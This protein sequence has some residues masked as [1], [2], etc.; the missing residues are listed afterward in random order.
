FYPYSEEQHLQEL[1][2]YKQELIAKYTKHGFDPNRSD[3]DWQKVHSDLERAKGYRGKSQALRQDFYQASNYLKESVEQVFENQFPLFLKKAFG[4]GG[5]D[6]YKI[7][8]L[9]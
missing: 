3:T 7:N 5:S 9:G 6:V 1:W 2:Q 8:S 4:G